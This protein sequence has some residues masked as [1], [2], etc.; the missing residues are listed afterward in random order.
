MPAPA[1]AKTYEELSAERAS[2]WAEKQKLAAKNLSDLH[3]QLSQMPDVREAPSPDL[4]WSHRDIVCP[5]QA[6]AG[7]EFYVTRWVTVN[8]VRHRAE[9]KCLGCGFLGTWDWALTAWLP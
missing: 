2:E 9:L 5:G 1:R 4:P 6:C 7:K 8:G 3:A